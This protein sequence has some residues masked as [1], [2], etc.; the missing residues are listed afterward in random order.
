MNQI[1]LNGKRESKF[2]HAKAA[3]NGRTQLARDSMM[4]VFLP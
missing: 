3:E 1:K 2:M 4:F